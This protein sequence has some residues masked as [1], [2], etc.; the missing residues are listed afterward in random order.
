MSRFTGLALLLSSVV[1]LPLAIACVEPL[2][3]SDAALDAGTDQDAHALADAFVPRDAPRGPDAGPPEDLEGAIDYWTVAGS[4][5]GVA[6]LAADEDT[7]IVVTSGMATETGAVDEHTLFNVASISKTFTCALALSLV[8]EGIL[9]LDAPLSEIVPEV[10][11]VHPSHPEIPVTTRMLLAH[12]SGLVDD[13]VFLNDYISTGTGD[14]PVDFEQFTR[15]YLADAS[16]WG[17]APGTSRQYCNANYGL[18]GLV[19]ESVSGRDFRDLSRERLFDPLDL[20]GAGWFF[21]D[22]ELDRVATPYSGT[23]RGYTALDH[24]QYAYYSAS[25]LMISVAGLER[26]L[27][28]HR[29]L[30]VLDGT[31]YF[32]ESSIAETR[33]AQYPEVDDG[34][35]LSWYAEST[36]GQRF[37]GHSGSSFGTSAQARYRAENGRILIVLSNSDAYIRSRVGIEEGAVAIRA[38]LDR[39]DAELDAR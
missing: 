27:R 38:I 32:D 7:R 18:L 36:R 15:E 28:L 8:E 23:R 16:H 3:P 10:A 34:Q 30:G 26:W 13:F 29:D 33:R 39:L 14:P 11:I 22:V 25:S 31:R 19:I 2:A 37:V 20:D 17:P 35:F 4:L 9:D 24:H 21:G 5:A 6:A 1:S 12:T